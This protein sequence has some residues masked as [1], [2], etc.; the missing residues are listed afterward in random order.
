MHSWIRNVAM[1]LGP[2]FLLV[3]CGIPDEPSVAR[4]AASAQ[5]APLTIAWE[6][7]ATNLKDPSG[8]RLAVTNV[9]N[10]DWDGDQRPDSRVNGFHAATLTTDEPT[11]TRTFSV[12]TQQQA[13]SFDLIGSNLERPREVFRARLT[14]QEEQGWNLAFH[15]GGTLPFAE[16]GTATQGISPVIQLLTSTTPATLT[17]TTPGT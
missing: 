9:A 12:S 15:N 1:L 17:I 5:T 13:V 4:L 11:L 7:E 6:H 3:A 14:Y 8:I 2:I 10:S 16:A